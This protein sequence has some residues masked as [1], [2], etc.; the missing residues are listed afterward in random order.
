MIAFLDADDT[1]VDSKLE[2]Q[3][4]ALDRYPE[5]ALVAGDMAETD[6]TG[7]V[8]VPS[9]LARHGLKEGF[10]RLMGA[11]V[12]NGAA[13]L[14]QKNF[15][16]TGTVLARTRVLRQLGGFNTSIRYEEDELWV[17]I[18]ARHAIACLPEVLMMRR[19]HGENVTGHSLQ[20]Q[21]DLVKVMRSLRGN[22]ASELRRQGVDPDRMV[23]N[24]LNDLGYWHFDH[25]DT[26]GARTAFLGSLRE[27]ITARGAAYSLAASLPQALS[28]R[29]RHAKQRLSNREAR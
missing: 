6:S 4:A 29:L 15:I 19:K 7:N 16:P 27:C 21:I 18:A 8:L 10:D 11:P 22:C 28:I 17:R 3:L 9:V 2:L 12:P 14:L 23:A 5:L 26:K 25:G 20:L 13:R 1:W 24:A